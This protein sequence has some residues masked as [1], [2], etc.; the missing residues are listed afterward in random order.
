MAQTREGTS[1]FS[2]FH[3]L[4]LKKVKSLDERVGLS[5]ERTIPV[6]YRE[7]FE[8]FLT[9]IVK[10]PAIPNPLCHV[11]SS[12]NLNMHN[13]CDYY[14]RISRPVLENYSKK[15]TLKGTGRLVFKNSVIAWR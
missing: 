11:V 5:E 13:S 3:V 15:R 1:A 6:E 14:L 2:D 4:L 12:V 9:F 8:M 7:N 10:D